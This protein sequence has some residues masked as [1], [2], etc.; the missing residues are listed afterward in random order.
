MI[1]SF[2]SVILFVLYGIAG[3]FGKMHIPDKFNGREWTKSYIRC[4]SIGFLTLGISYIIFSLIE[5]YC[6]L[7]IPHK[8]NSAGH[9]YYSSDCLRTNN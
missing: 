9:I 2:I 6:K 4:N 8:L 7:N 5:Y 1:T 3:M